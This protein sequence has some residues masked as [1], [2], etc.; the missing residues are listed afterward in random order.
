MR[1]L[2]EKR[3]GRIATGII[4]ASTVVT[5]ARIAASCSFVAFGP[6]QIPTHKALAACRLS[7]QLNSIAEFVGT[8]A[9]QRA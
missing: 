5:S 4:A 6:C 3:S 2:A 8:R 9:L 1:V 7:V